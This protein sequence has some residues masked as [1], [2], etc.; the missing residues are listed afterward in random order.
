MQLN[1]LEKTEL[2][3]NNVVMQDANLSDIAAVTAAVLLLPPDKVLV[4]DVRADHFCLDILEKSLSME[5]IVGKEQ[6]LLARLGEVPGLTITEHTYIESQGIMGLINCEPVSSDTVVSRT[7]QMV[8][9]I[10]QRVLTRALVYATGFEVEQGLIEDTNSPFLCSVLQDCGYQTEFGGIIPDSKGMIAQKLSE[11]V[12]RGF[13]LII[14]TGGVGAEDKDFSVE[15]LQKLDKAALT[16]YIIQFEQGTGRHLKDGVR[17]GVGQ[18]GLATIINLPG[19]NDE[20]KVA[21]TAVAN[22]CRA[23]SLID[24]GALANT[25]AQ[26]LRSKLQQ[27]QGGCHAHGTCGDH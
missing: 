22:Y 2:R 7:Q 19:P 21:A 4:I 11:A 12:D 10:E 5:Q 26:V 13:G 18:V 17:I 14:T 23:G 8:S 15:A 16:P 1:L 24:R 3:I 25:I 20:V 6:V 9:E 27:K